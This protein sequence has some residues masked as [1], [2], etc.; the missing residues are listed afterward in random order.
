MR[1]P[2]NAV[3]GSKVVKVK[4]N[5]SYPDGVKKNNGGK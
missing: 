5:T 1:D 2:R 4:T 3:K